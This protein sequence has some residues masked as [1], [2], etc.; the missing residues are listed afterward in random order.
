MSFSLQKIKTFDSLDA[1]QENKSFS[2]ITELYSKLKKSHVLETEYENSKF[3]CKTLKMKNLSHMNNFRNFQNT[4]LLCKVIENRFENMQK[5]CGFNPK[6]YN[7]AS[8]SSGC[9]ER[10]QILSN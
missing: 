3:V 4:C 8:T 5:S 10:D 7:S 6:R 2:E 1:V 9:I